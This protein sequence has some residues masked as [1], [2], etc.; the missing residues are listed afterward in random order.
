MKEGEQPGK[1][2]F[3]QPRRGGGR[4]RVKGEG[5]RVRSSDATSCT[6]VHVGSKPPEHCQVVR[7]V[8][9]HA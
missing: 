9:R 4:S 6:S 7:E 2:A 1:L 8:A 5:K 3:E